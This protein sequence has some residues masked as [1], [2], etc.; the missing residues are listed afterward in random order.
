MSTDTRLIT[1]EDFANMHF[2][3]PVELV[4]G[5]IIFPYGGDGMTRPDWKH[6][7]VCARIASRLDIWCDETD[8]GSV[9]SND[10]GILIEKDPDTLRG[11]DVFFISM[12][13]LPGGVMPAGVHDLVPNLCIEVWSPSDRWREMHRKI[14]AYLERGVSEVWL[15]HPDR[16]TIVVFRADE[17]P[18]VFQCS[19][20][21][22]SR[23]LP[24]FSCL[25]SSFFKG[26]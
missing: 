23:E 25:V 6:G 18:R 14:D 7:R 10:P 17:A 13:R 15:V 5:E 2:D 9:T 1:A 8:A 11:P 24:G 22:E 4:Q 19:E 21:I 16:R 3:A 20:T 26:I 12:D